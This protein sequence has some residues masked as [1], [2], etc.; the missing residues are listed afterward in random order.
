MSKKPYYKNPLRDQNPD[1][2]PYVPQYRIK[3]LEPTPIATGSVAEAGVKVGLIKQTKLPVS[4]NNPRIRPAPSIS[5]N[6]PYAE[7]PPDTV[8]F[9]P[10]IPNVGNN[11]ENTWAGVDGDI[12]DEEDTLY[13]KLDPNHPMIDNNFDDSANYAD[14]PDELEAPPTERFEYQHAVEDPREYLLFV[15]E[16]MIA[17]GNLEGI[18]AEVKSLVFGEHPLCKTTTVENDDIVVFKK[19]KIKVGVF[20]E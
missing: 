6:V 2:K 17:T 14:I 16:K 11:V 18:E 12:F 7:L 19:M 13:E 15:K 10:P 4:N 9:G 20:I 3:G 1:F 5:A 8:K